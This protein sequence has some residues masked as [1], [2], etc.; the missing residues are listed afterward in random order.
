MDLYYKSDGERLNSQYRSYL[1]LHQPTYCVSMIAKE[2]IVASQRKG[3]K[4]KIEKDRE[5]L[6]EIK[7]TE[8]EKDRKRKG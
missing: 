8:R 5:R 3:E 1:D 7:E 4:E 2:K 6:R